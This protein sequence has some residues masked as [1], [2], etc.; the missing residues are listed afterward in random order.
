MA[1]KYKEPKVTKEMAELAKEFNKRGGFD[2][3]E[4]L[5]RHREPQAVITQL[6]A[7]LAKYGG[8]RFGCASKITQFKKV[9][10]DY[11]VFTGMGKCDCG[12]AEAEERWG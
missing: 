10:Y 2:I 1:E 7:D 8:H 5:N 3:E 4:E 12:F 6:K 9:D 11:N